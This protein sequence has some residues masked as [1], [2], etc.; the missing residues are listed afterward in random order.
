LVI[1]G[2]VPVYDKKQGHFLVHVPF[3][4]ERDVLRGQSELDDR[5]EY[6]KS[7]WIQTD[8]VLHALKARG[9][10]T[11]YLAERF[12]GRCEIP[13]LTLVIKQAHSHG[14]RHVVIFAPS[15]GVSQE[16]IEAYLESVPVP[17]EDVYQ[18]AQAMTSVFQAFFEFKKKTGPREIEKGRESGQEQ[19]LS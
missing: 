2:A 8:A 6:L 5:V 4:C 3:A 14:F 11:L 17:N 9:V 18:W 1:D 12:R 13:F 19:S 10:H 7:I 16:D 15:G